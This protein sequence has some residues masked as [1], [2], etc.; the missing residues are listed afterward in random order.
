[1]VVKRGHENF[2]E[3]VYDGGVE[4]ARGGSPQ[5]VITA[6]NVGDAC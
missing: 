6:E 5:D 2:G 3:R 1:M 4:I